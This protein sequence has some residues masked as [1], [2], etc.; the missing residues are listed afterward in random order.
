MDGCRLTME[1]ETLFENVDLA[2]DALGGIGAACFGPDTAKTDDI[3]I[4]V[5]EAMNN[6][7][8]HSG[9][10]TVQLAISR[11]RTELRIAVICGGPRF[12]PTAAAAGLEPEDMLERDEGGYGLYLIR[13]LVDRFVYEYR[14][15]HNIWVLIKHI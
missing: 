11:D 13:Q 9:S 4:A 14:D 15:S 7:V 3:M 12:D 10:T 5:T 2:R 6:V 8:E 1:F